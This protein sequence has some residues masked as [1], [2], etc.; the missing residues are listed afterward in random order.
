MHRKEKNHLNYASID[1]DIA[2]HAL[3]FLKSKFNLDIKDVTF[4]IVYKRENNNMDLEWSSFLKIPR[5]KIL[6]RFSKRHK[7]ESMQ[8]EVSGL[9]F[10][11]IFDCIFERIINSDFIDDKELRRA[12]LKGIFA[13]EGNIGID[14][15]E[16][17]HYIHQISFAI[18]TEEEQLKNLI[19][20]CLEEENF[21]YR[22]DIDIK[23]HSLRINISNW[24]NYI[25]FWEINLFDYC[26]RK[27]TLFKKISKNLDVYF[28]IK[29]E[30]RESFFKSLNMSQKEIA[31]KIDSWQGNVCKTIQG[32]HLLKIEQ[33]LNFTSYKKDELIKNTDSIR[34][35]SLTKLEINKTVLDFLKEFRLF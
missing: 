22:F 13:A 15:H 30:F 8:I 2:K 10:R 18:S 26:E 28:I 31:E 32:I 25:K 4:T 1:K 35:G 12:F 7:N 33:V 24:Q 34:I 20:K 14:Y 5:E 29:N 19:C 17:K 16:K 11:K 21:L 6:K 3:D 9:I 23:R 27:K